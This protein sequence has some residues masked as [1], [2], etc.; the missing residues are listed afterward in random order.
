MR[1]SRPWRW[2]ALAAGLIACVL[3]LS[4]A[5]SVAQARGLPPGVQTGAMAMDSAT[6]HYLVALPSSNAVFVMSSK[7]QQVVTVLRVP[8][9]PAGIAI[10]PVRRL[11]YIS[12]DS[13]GMISVFDSR[14][15]AVVRIY[16]VGGHPAGL[17]LTPGGKALLFTD[18][19]SGIINRL[20]LSS[21]AEQPEQ[22]LQVGPGALPEL[23][24]RSVIEGQSTMLWARGFAPG[25]PVA[26]YWVYWGSKP[27]VRTT[28]SAAGIVT[29]PVL[30][31]AKVGIGEH[32]LII[33]GTRST[34]SQSVLL[35]VRPLPPAPKRRP[36]PRPPKPGLVGRLLAPSVV[37]PNPLAAMG[38]KGT[39]KAKKG[40]VARRVAVQHPAASPGIKVPIIAFAAVPLLLLMIRLPAARRRRRVRKAEKA[41]QAA[42]KQKGGRRGRRST[43]VKQA[44]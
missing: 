26:V 1:Q 11:T 44:S 7:D 14:S 19:A 28:A 13:A 17:T 43:P 9:S 38:Q 35:N 40:Q 18:D 22:L 36:K 5:A 8:P 21:K 27:L 33:Y 41:A 24:P 42:V 6:G 10:D 32:M 20:S 2:P 37:V 25:E 4:G 3:G 34:K 30:V 16:P 39:P 23:G 15:Y 29:V 31:P 12:S